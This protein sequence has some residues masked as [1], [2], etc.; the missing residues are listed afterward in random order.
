MIAS[1]DAFPRWRVGLKYAKV[2]IVISFR[3]PAYPT[4]Q[5][6]VASLRLTKLGTEKS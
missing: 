5:E 3:R 6:I 2:L 1:S 4:H